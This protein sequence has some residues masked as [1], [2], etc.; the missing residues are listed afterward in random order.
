[1][2]FQVQE[3]RP[4]VLAFALLME[5]R[6]REKDADKGTSWKQRTFPD[7]AVN[8]AMK[9]SQLESCIRFQSP[10]MNMHAVDLA[11]CCMFIADNAGALKPSAEADG[12]FALDEVAP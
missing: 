4:E 12:W 1:M 2:K 11:N 10:N 7:L 6:L 8:V 9:K 5:K 3:L